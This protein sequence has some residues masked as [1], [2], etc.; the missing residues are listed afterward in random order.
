MRRI[1]LF[2]TCALILPTVLFGSNSKAQ[3]VN[4]TSP[5]GVI[6]L[7]IRITDQKM[8]YDVAYDGEV[9][10]SNNKLGLTIDHNTLPVRLK[11]K[12]EARRHQSFDPVVPLKFSHIEKEYNELV[13]KMKD[14]YSIVWRAY[15]DGIAYR[16]VTEFGG[17]IHVSDEQVELGVN[18]EYVIHIQP[19]H[20]F[21]SAFE[22]EYGHILMKQWQTPAEMSNIP[23]LIDAGKCMILFSE[24][25]HIDYPR[26]FF[27]HSETGMVQKFP[28]VW[29]ETAPV[30][31]RQSRPVREADYIAETAGSRCFPW[32][33]MVIGSDSDLV[34][35]TM[36]ACLSSDSCELDDTSWIEPG[37]VAWDWWNGKCVWGPDV[38][39]KTG[40][41]TETYKYY[42]DFAS[43]YGLK[44]IILDEGWNVNVNR[45]FD[46]IPEIDMP[47]LVAYGKERNV[48]LILWVSWYAVLNNPDIFKTYSDWGVKGMKIDFMNR[49]DQSIVHFYENTLR[50]AAKNHLI[51]DFHGAMTPGGME[52]RF[53]NLMA[54][55]GVRG[56]EWNDKCIPDN[57]L[58]LP[59]IRNAVGAMDFT[60]G[61]MVCAQPGIAG[62]HTY[63]PIPIGL[64]TRAYHM[65]LFITCETGT[66]M[67]ADS[68]TRYYQNPECTDFITSVP[69]TWDE[70][71]VL[72]AKAGQYL[73]EAKRKGDKWFIAGI[74]NHNPHSFEISLDFLNDGEQYTM[75]SF[76]DGPNAGYQALDCRKSVSQVTSTQT[77]K[78]EMAGNGGFAA[79]ISR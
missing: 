2:A 25:D 7:N 14:H 10:L 46:I 68:P 69:V 1:L 66:Q 16:F 51:I 28:K 61:A 13:L 71:R 29:L 63:I 52:Y 22:N 31:D 60:P 41:N 49:T 59:F 39:F 24:A 78:I 38:D 72:K 8:T 70:T 4:L 17:R 18:P 58:Y 37:Q 50:E 76:R 34:T 56:L 20:S 26:M 62:G 33:Y 19:E 23:V 74:G 64:G 54:Y 43:R 42:I 44:Y 11:S 75:T 32:R 73:V 48:G 9:V 12:T 35:N 6:R 5:D 55:E 77:I 53:P 40:I 57:C 67:L 27:T 21:Q 15:N 79:V 3:S 65:A 47:E 30:G 36:N 45:P